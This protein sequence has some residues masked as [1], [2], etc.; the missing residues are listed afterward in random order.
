MST[1]I[2]DEYKLREKELVE[3]KGKHYEIANL[4]EIREIGNIEDSLIQLEA[5]IENLLTE[6]SACVNDCSHLREELRSKKEERISLKRDLQQLKASYYPMVRE[7]NKTK[8]E[9]EA[10]Q[11]ALDNVSARADLK[12]KKIT[13]L[14]VILQNWLAFYAKLEGGFAH[15]DYDSQWAQNTVALNQKYQGT[16]VFKQIPTRNARIS[17]NFIGSDDKESYLASMPAILD[18]AINGIKFTPWGE[19]NTIEQTSLPSRIAGSIRLSLIGGCPMYYKNF[20]EGDSLVKDDSV[21][22]RMN[23]ALNATYEYPAAFKFSVTA[24]YNLYKMYEKMSTATSHGGF[25]SQENYNSVV[26]DRDDNDTFLIDWHLEDEKYD[27]KAQEE[28][29][30]T[31]KT[32]LMG[33]VLNTLATP[34]YTNSHVDEA[35]VPTSTGHGALVIAEG[36]NRTCGYF[37]LFC[38]G[39]VWV[40]RGLDAIFGSSSAE[41]KF[42]T[43]HN[44]TAT[45]AWNT[46]ETRWRTGATGLAGN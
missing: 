11:Y 46:S 5:R 6:I 31:L 28:I 26:E 4:P 44:R 37:N 45:E 20:L 14:K 24:K 40:F 8:A 13:E 23:F 35:R 3:A 38:Q 1:A 27:A 15:V 39:A 30:K 33:R 41:S 25:F 36:I 10:A 18:Y 19:S 42:R 17:A 32:E 12:L 29:R 16:Y 34:I 9:L 2:G 7:F 43:T 22:K 21:N